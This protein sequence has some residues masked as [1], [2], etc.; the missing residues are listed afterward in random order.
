MKIISKEANPSGSYFSPQ[1]WPDGA[2]PPEGMAVWQGTLD[3]ADFYAHNG[4][5]ILHVEQVEGMDT[6]TSYE[7]N[8][9]A[10]Q[11]WKASLPSEPGP[12]PEPTL[13]E[14]VAGIEAAIQEGLSLYEGDLGNG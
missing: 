12:D 10:W 7:P 6:V 1:D 9:E 5:V 11:E 14:R 2:A 4:F 8:T 3:T 13:E